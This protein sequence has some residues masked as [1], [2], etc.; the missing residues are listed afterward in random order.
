LDKGEEVFLTDAYTA[1]PVT[2]KLTH[3]DQG[4]PIVSL[5]PGDGDVRV[6]KEGVDVLELIQEGIGA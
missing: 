4:D 6:E 1:A 3:S 2:L 5:W